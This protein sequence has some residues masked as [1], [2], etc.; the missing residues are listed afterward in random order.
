MTEPLPHGSP[1]WGRSQAG[2]GGQDSSTSGELFTVAAARDFFSRAYFVGDVT[3]VRFA[4]QL[5]SS[6]D[7]S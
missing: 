5:A 6:A 1:D 2:R 7:N 4:G 3:H